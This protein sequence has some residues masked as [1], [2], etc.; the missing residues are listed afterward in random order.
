M[1]NSDLPRVTPVRLARTALLVV[2]GVFALATVLGGFGALKAG[3]VSNA[4]R[5]RMLLDGLV[6]GASILIVSWQLILQPTL[7]ASSHKWLSDTI[8]VAYPVGDSVAITLALVIIARARHGSEVRMA[9][10]L[11][12]AAG[13]L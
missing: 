9:T 2:L 1:A 4:S 12:L 6:I 3:A 13:I 10:I 8:S 7:A 5:T 11:M